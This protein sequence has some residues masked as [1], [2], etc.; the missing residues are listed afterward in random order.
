MAAVASAAS[1]ADWV[2]VAGDVGGGGAENAL[3]CLR[4]LDAACDGRV[5]YVPGNHDIWCAPA[6]GGDSWDR[7]RRLLTFPGNLERG[8]RDL[9]GGLCA[10]GT[11][12]W[13]DYAFAPPGPWGEAELQNGSWGTVRWRDAEFARWGA[14]APE[15]CAAFARLLEER[16]GEAAAAGLRPVVVTHVV[17]CAP[18]LAPVGDDPAR[19]FSQAF[20][21]SPRYGELARRFG[22]ALAVFG[23][24]HTRST[25]QV[26]GVPYVCAPLGYAREWRH[27]AHPVR[28]V[29]EAMVT[30]EVVAGAAATAPARVQPWKASGPESR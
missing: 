4:E 10:V 25:G 7:W 8:N 1:A 30:V 6:E 15:V 21:G 2:L 26:E 9:G 18:A 5:L 24:T 23:H 22:A 14:P 12:G 19:A 13:Y 27:T 29:A 20:M 16:L 28:E 11:G 17:Q 3:R